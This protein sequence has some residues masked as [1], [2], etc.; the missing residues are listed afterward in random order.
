MVERLL[1]NVG[2]TQ[3]QEQPAA[4]LDEFPR[5]FE[6]AQTKCIDLEA[7]LF[8]RQA[9]GLHEIDQVISQQADH[10]AGMVLQE[11]GTVGLVEIEAVLC[12]LDKIFHR[13]PVVV[14][15]EH[16]PGGQFLRAIRDHILV[17]E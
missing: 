12:F 7:G 10:H 4:A 17:P 13:P 5:H 3:F 15:L 8:R 11:G 9:D 2:G 16:R 1:V 14:K 6:Q